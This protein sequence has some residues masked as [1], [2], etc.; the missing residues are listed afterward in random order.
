MQC[1]YLS[2]KMFIFLKP[3]SEINTPT[4]LYSEVSMEYVP[5]TFLFEPSKSLYLKWIPYKQHTIGSYFYN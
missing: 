5:P 4:L 2:L 3:L 1:P